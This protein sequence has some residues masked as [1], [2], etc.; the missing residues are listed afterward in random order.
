MPTVVLIS[1]R[2]EYEYISLFYL[3]TKQYRQMNRGAVAYSV[4]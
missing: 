4:Y 1:T 3:E 2:I